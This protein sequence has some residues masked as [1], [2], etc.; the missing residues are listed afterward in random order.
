M[1]NPA[2]RRVLFPAERRCSLYYGCGIL[3]L[4]WNANLSEKVVYAKLDSF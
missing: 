1:S 3:K 4:Q 2:K